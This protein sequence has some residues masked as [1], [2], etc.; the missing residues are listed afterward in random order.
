MSCRILQPEEASAVGSVRWSSAPLAPTGEVKPLF[1]APPR[2]QHSSEPSEAEVFN[3]RVKQLQAEC[4]Q[5]V[6]QAYRQGRSEGE[7]SA[8]EA[9]KKQY[10]AKLKELAQAL[11]SLASLRSR[12]RYEAE[13]DLVKLS[14]EVARRVL[15]R[16]LSVDSDALRGIVKACLEQLDQREIRRLR[17]HPE[18]AAS[19][20]S[21]MAERN[22]R[23]EITADSTLSPGSVVFETSQGELDGSIETQ[24]LEIERGFSDMLPRP[25]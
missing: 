1:G 23:V 21:S 11:E 15:R 7:A 25:R 18:Q 13:R 12:V 3:S 8:T 20:G 24:L 6:Q 10:G 9:A 14:I 22:V 17:L 16:E 5:K 2:P 19:L 4:E